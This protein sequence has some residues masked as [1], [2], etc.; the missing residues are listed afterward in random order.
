[1]NQLLQNMQL[2]KELRWEVEKV[3]QSM[4][5]PLEPRQKAYQHLMKGEFLPILKRDRCNISQLHSEMDVRRYK[6]FLPSNLPALCTAS[7]ELRDEATPVFL[8]NSIIH[9]KGPIYKDMLLRF[10]KSLPNKTGFNAIRN[11]R[12]TVEDKPYW[13]DV[14]FYNLFPNLHTV[15]FKLDGAQI[16]FL[17]IVPRKL[18]PEQVFKWFQTHKLLPMEEIWKRMQANSIFECQSLK[19]VVIILKKF[20]ITGFKRWKPVL[21]CDPEPLMAKLIKWIRE[22]FEARGMNVDVELKCE[23]DYFEEWDKMPEEEAINEE[24]E[25]MMKLFDSA[26]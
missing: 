25:E 11:I 24:N 21:E 4:Q 12:Y 26:F 6:P 14:E 20:D 19:K 1:M 23:E 22:Q 3:P 15:E 8:E 16:A 2:A 18:Q 10:L 9:V 5:I 7:P 13:D 17:R